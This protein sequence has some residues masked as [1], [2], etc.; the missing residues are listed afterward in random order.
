MPAVTP[1]QF[2][3]GVGA[4][5]ALTDVS[6]YVEAGEGIGRSYG[7]QDQFRDTEPGTFTITLNNRDGRFTP[8]NTVSPYA[9]TVTEGMAVNLNVGGRF[10]SGTV[11]AIALPADEQTWGQI[12]LTCDDMLGNASR[13]ALG[14]LVDSINAGATPY[15]LFPLDDVA[16]TTTPRETANAGSGLL[17]LT[18]S[19]GS[20]FGGA[21]IPGLS[22]ATQLTLK[23]SLASPSGTIWP[24]FAFTYPTSSLGFYSFWITPVSGAKITAS[25]G[26]SGLAR[27]FQFGYT[28]GAYF[29]RDG[30]SGT[31]AT[32]ASVD[33]GPH[34]VS[35]GLGS[36]FAAGVWT[37]TATLYVD[38][39]SRGSIVYGSTPA[40]L[41]YRAPVSMS[42]VASV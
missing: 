1:I 41:T 17:T 33:T 22:A 37:I 39:T 12:T 21:A 30:D 3:L 27:T 9:T 25:V 14:T 4:S 38:G 11:L 26:I 2:A 23:D 13:R 7:K 5:G 42:L 10:T 36:T 24:T 29:V 40:T 31:P 35:M 20:A 6:T 15:I 16:G 28:G 8:N 19:S 18:G 32:Y 34:F